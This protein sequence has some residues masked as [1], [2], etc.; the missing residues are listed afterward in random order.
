M[1]SEREREKGKGG[2]VG[3]FTPICFGSFFFCQYIISL[4]TK[5]LWISKGADRYVCLYVGLYVSA[6]G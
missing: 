3:C 5:A 4:M 6:I 1:Y 2:G